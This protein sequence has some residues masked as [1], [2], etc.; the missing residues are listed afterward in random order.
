MYVSSP[1]LASLISRLHERDKYRKYV[2]LTTERQ[3]YTAIASLIRTREM[4]LLPSRLQM[5]DLTA[6]AQNGM[7]ALNATAF[8]ARNEPSLGWVGCKGTEGK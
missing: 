4:Y 3:S 2:T 6:F 7:K 1:H 5:E 8:K